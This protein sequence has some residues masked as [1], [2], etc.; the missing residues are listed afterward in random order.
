LWRGVARPRM[1][2]MTRHRSRSSRQTCE[3]HA[4]R[5]FR[6]RRR[7]HA[8]IELPAHTVAIERSLQRL[9]ERHLLQP[10][11][12]QFVAS[13]Y[14]IGTRHD[15]RIDTLGI[16]RHGSPV[17]IEYKRGLSSNLISQGLFYLDWLDEHRGEF[18]LL[19][20]ERLGESMAASI[21]W[22][23]PRLICVAAE[24]HRYDLRAVRQIQRHI[25]LIRYLRFG[26][27]LLLLAKL[28]VQPG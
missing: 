10:L 22:S 15:G 18:R 3:G 17:V 20:H 1:E 19:V 25:E 14:P 24:F 8:I 11:D 7:G 26:E 13:E 9:M 12:V 28:T 6:L 5:L 2:T 23:A 4:P 16:D 21:A 27:H